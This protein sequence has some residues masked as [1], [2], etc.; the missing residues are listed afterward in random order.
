MKIGYEKGGQN[1]SQNDRVGWVA[2]FSFFN[3]FKIK[4]CRKIK[5]ITRSDQNTE[6]IIN[7]SLIA[8]NRELW[9]PFAD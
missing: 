4:I 1:Y 5:S 6:I 2:P 8:Q 3:S 9:Y 7:Y